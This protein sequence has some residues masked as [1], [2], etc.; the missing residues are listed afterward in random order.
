[1][2]SLEQVLREEIRRLARK[3]AKAQLDAVKRGTAHYRKEIAAL[4]RQVDGLERRCAFLES[5]E[6]KRLSQQK[7]QETSLD[8]VRF[9]ARS[10]RSHRR[11]LNLS[12]ED[13]GQ[14]VGVS[15]QTVYHW[16]RGLSRPRKSQLAALVEVRT[17]GKREARERLK[18]L[19]ADADV[20]ERL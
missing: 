9:S 4:R 12:A 18:L 8:E 5:Q 16:E 11:R 20:T 15:A 2:P 10:V 19:R 14:L 3:E 7:D 17:I 1:M 13:Y 6:R